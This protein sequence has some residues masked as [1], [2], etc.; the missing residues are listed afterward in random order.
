MQ[1]FFDTFAADDFYNIVAKGET[2]HNKQFLLLSQYFP[3]ILSIVKIY[4]IYTYIFSKSSAAEA[5]TCIY[6]WEKVN[7]NTVG[8]NSYYGL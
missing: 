5:S 1:T 7:C 8:S 6:I 2:A 4:S 3:H